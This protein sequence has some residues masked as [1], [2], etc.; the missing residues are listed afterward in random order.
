MIDNDAES[1]TLINTFWVR[2]ENQDELLD[3]LDETTRR[4]IRNQP[5]FMGA[6][7]QRSLDGRRVVSYSKWRSK[8]DIE[9]MQADTDC[10]E[11]MA[12]A[13]ALADRFELT[14]YAVSSIH[15]RWPNASLPY[16]PDIFVSL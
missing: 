4:I 1:V 14:L 8:E 9:A 16:S 13:A 6:S 3:V 10:R 5:G 11:H 15:E 12:Q 2:P 7:L